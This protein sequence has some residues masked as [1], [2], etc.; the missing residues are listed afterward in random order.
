MSIS[1]LIG[2]VITAHVAVGQEALWIGR[3]VVRQ[4]RARITTPERN[5]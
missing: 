2:L 5:A 4:V 1:E 3:E